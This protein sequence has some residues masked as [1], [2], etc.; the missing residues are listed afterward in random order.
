MEKAQQMGGHVAD[1]YLK[2]TQKKITDS[3]VVQSHCFQASVP[4]N[5]TE[6]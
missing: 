6:L 3:E 5:I 1:I 2:N 4:C